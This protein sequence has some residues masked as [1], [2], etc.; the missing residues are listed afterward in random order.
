MKPFH[1]IMTFLILSFLIKDAAAQHMNNQKLE[2]I[3]YF[4]SDTMSGEVGSWQFVFN[5]IPM[6]CFTDETHNRMRIIA[7]IKIMEAVSNEEMKACMEA[8]F[9]TALDVKY[10]VSEDVMWSVYIHPLK[11]LEK[12]QV[13]NAIQQ[14]CNAHV[15]YGT[16]Y[17]ST[18]LVFPK[19]ED[20]DSEKEKK[21]SPKKKLK[22]SR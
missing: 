15:T 2:Q 8:N 16:I 11:E 6:F 18:D 4:V 9:H 22:R 20:Q 7:P 19:S 17:S 3:I 21:K 13:I 14:V 1:I 5:D 12:D 10:A